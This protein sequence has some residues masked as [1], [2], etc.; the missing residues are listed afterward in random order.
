M[1]AWIKARTYHICQDITPLLAPNHPACLAVTTGQSIAIVTSSSTSSSTTIANIIPNESTMGIHAFQTPRPATSRK[2]RNTTTT[3]S[4][5]YHIH[6]ARTLPRPS[7]TSPATPDSKATSTTSAGLRGSLRPHRA[8]Y[9]PSFLRRKA[10]ALTPLPADQVSTTSVN[11]LQPQQSSCDTFSVTAP[12][13]YELIEVATAA[14]TPPAYELVEVAMAALLP[15]PP[16]VA[17]G[18]VAATV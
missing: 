18:T 7:T 13:A 14:P 3:T 17:V 11:D 5:P 8:S 16:Y 4:Q 2:H 12:P 6:N 15:P 10:I 1:T 9:L